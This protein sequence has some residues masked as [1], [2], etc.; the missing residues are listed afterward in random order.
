MSRLCRFRREPT[1]SRAGAKYL[2]DADAFK[3]AA[4]D[5]ANAD[6]VPKHCS[7]IPAY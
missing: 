1:S 2:A 7:I 4:D 6:F 5:I 3:A